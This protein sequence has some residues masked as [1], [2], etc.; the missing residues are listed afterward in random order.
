MMYQTIMI[1]EITTII[2]VD[3][4]FNEA[5]GY[6]PFGLSSYGQTNITAYAEDLDAGD[7]VSYS[8][9]R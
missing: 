3:D 6:D 4:R 7:S 8:L 2:D 5:R 1:M 9:K